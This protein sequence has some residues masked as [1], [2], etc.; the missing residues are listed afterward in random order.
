MTISPVTGIDELR[1]DRV[2]GGSWLAR[3]AVEALLQEAA[4]GAD[5]A[6]ELRERLVK[7]ARDLVVSRPDSGSVATAV[8]RL[9]AVAH[10]SWVLSVNELR[11]L[12]LDEARALLG[13][14]DR[15]ARSIAIQLAPRL[16][17]AVVVTHSASATVREAV[18]H[19]PPRRLICTACEPLGEGR[20][21]ADELREHGL[22]VTLVGDAD[23]ASALDEATLV[24]VG[25]DT[26]YLD[27]TLANRRGTHSL[28]EAAHGRGIPVVVACEVIKLAPFDPPDAPSDPD[29]SDLTP[30]GLIAEISTEEGAVRPD[31]IAA[32]VERTPLLREG[33]ALLR[34]DRS[35]APTQ[36][37]FS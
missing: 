11:R 29:L 12:V 5:S 7:T 15:A 6:D 19:T 31:E 34:G 26:I 32:L 16:A 33:Y 18:T 24:L 23:A 3:I 2:H 36:R 17:D 28:A 4:A 22:N 9:L 35:A 21:F 25:A 20:E 30:P 1:L 8:A 14:R 27:G 10:G 13:A 37:S